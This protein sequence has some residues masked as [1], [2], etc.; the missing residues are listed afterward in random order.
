[1]KAKDEL[2]QRTLIA[3]YIILQINGMRRP[4]YGTPLHSIVMN[5]GERSSGH[6]QHQEL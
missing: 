6:L 4:L 3:N 1:M 5:D 2:M